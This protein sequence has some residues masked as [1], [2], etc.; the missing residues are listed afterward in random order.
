LTQIASQQVRVF[1][2]VICVICGQNDRALEINTCEEKAPSAFK[3]VL[4]VESDFDYY[5]RL[6]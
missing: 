3:T 2:C 4:I 5:K 6:G 1:I